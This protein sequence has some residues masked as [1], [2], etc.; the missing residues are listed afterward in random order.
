MINSS[1]I[2]KVW[3]ECTCSLPVNQDSPRL[4][5]II[6]AATIL[7]VIIVVTLLLSSCGPA[8]GVQLSQPVFSVVPQT[9]GYEVSDNFITPV[10]CPGAVCENNIVSLVNEANSSI[11]IMIYSFTL[12]DIASALCDAVDRG[13][14]VRVLID[15]QQAGN[16]YS[17]DEVLESC[18][19][20]LARDTNSR[21][22]HNKVMIVDG[23]ILV[24]GSFN[25]SKNARDFNDENYLI[26]VNKQLAKKYSDYF[27]K[28]WYRDYI[29]K[30]EKA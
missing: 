16:Q 3:E 24:T 27:D 5:P 4:N 19:V 8:P 7:F 11:D 23:F 25:W 22:M 6:K 15:S 29:S 21:L 1:W 17:V 12:N 10:F 14:V 2:D 20:L 30:G 26:I 18:G 13:V 28:L 9:P